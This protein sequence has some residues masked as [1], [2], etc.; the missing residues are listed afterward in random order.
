MFGKWAYAQTLVAFF[1][2]FGNLGL[3]VYGQ[4]QV[5]AD[6][7][8]RSE[9]IPL[10]VS[11]RF[12]LGILSYI[13]LLLSIFFL[14]T[15]TVTAKLIAIFGLTMITSAVCNLEWIFVGLQKFQI[16][17]FLQITSQLI[18]VA[19]IIFF[20]RTADRVYLLPGLILMGGMVSGVIG[21]RWLK[22]AS[23]SLSIKFE[24]KKWLSILHI[25][26]YFFLSS[27]MSMIYNKADHLMLS[28]MK[29]D[30]ALGQYAACYT[31][32]GAAM[33][34]V[35]VGQVVLA[36]LSTSIFSEQQD[37]LQSVLKR[38]FYLLTVFALPMAVGSA[39]LANQL[40]SLILGQKY[41]ES[42]FLFRLLCLVIPAGIGASFFAGT[43][44]ITL[45]LYRQYLIAVLCGA[46]LNI[47]LNIFFIP[48]FGGLGA[49][50]T[51]A[52]S[53]LAVAVSAGYMG[54]KYISGVIDIDLTSPL[55][56]SVFMSVCL[57]LLGFLTRGLI[58]LVIA[59]IVTYFI[60][61]YCAERWIGGSFYSVLTEYRR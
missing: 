31:L 40:V 2:I 7:E 28:W 56:S 46:V 41:I 9:F 47:V 24:P 55:F 49:A 17:T 29:G 33:G 44:L 35:L 54:R 6:K 57:I 16:I 42:A 27:L 18:Y 8:G 23:L 5:A 3:T 53:Q 32:V 30:Y 48:A 20:L 38:G 11:F 61:L 10:L 13:L 14:D 12:F 37:K 39:I 4:R 1:T 58:P 22:K 60:M 36:P 45:G 26:F 15:E 59:G 19:G 52:L 25:S 34:L 43:V 50:I 21:W 51:T